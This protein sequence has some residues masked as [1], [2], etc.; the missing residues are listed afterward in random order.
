MLI[1]SSIINYLNVPLP[2]NEELNREYLT[3][4]L[5]FQ[6][7]TSVVITPT[8]EEII[9][10]LS[11][12]DLS[13]NKH[14]YAITTGLLFAILHLPDALLNPILLFFTIVYIYYKRIKLHK[15]IEE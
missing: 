14:I 13:S 12:K 3:T 7:I 4:K 10:R 15:A 9:F 2:L 11:T 1:S 5:I 8:I 6:I